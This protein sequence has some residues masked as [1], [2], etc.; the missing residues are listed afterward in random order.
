MATLALSRVVTG[1]TISSTTE[2]NNQ[3]SLETVINGGLD[4]A[5]LSGSAGI[6]YANCDSNTVAG[7]T[8]TQTITNKTVTQSTSGYTDKGNSGGGTVTIDMNDANTQKVTLTGNPTLAFNNPKNFQR[9]TLILEQDGSGSRT[10]TWPTSV[11]WGNGTGATNSTTDAPTLTTTA[12]KTD[13]FNFIY[14]SDNSIWLGV[15]SGFTF[16]QS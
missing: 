4:N 10:V 15:V 8:A 11:R 13:I 3:S 14:D 2:N 1:T 6:T 5:N 9:L 7:R 16:A 12:N